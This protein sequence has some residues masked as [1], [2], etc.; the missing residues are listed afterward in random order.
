MPQDAFEKT[1]LGW[2]IQQLQQKFGE[3]LE[4]KLSQ[5]QPKLP[6]VKLP[7]WLKDLSFPEWLPKTLFW[8]MVALLVSWIALQVLRLSDDLRLSFPISLNN[9][10]QDKNNSQGNDLTVS[11]WIKRSQ[12]LYR[13]GNYKEAAR[14]LYMGTLQRLNDTGIAPHQPSRTDGEY[15]KITQQLPQEMSYQMLLNTHEQA[16]FSNREI[17]PED[18]ERCQQAYQDIERG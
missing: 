9:A 17:L 6:N 1:N 5:N 8:L 4:L 18:V 3:W 11:A 2:Q 15:R 10:N 14:C 12:E 7:P 16:C 13:Q